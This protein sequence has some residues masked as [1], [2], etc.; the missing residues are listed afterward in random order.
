[1][2]NWFRIEADGAVTL[3]VH[4]QPGAR[5]TAVAGLHGES[6]KIRVA[7]PALE[8]RAN[9]ALVDFLAE[10]FGV[11]RRAVTLVGGARSREKRL[12]VRGSTRAPEKALG[13]GS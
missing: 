8:D 4:I 12:E 11:P 10:A 9:E 2:A 3:R 1:M 13:V 5:R 7:A 6:V